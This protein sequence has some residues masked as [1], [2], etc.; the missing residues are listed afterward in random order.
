MRREPRRLVDRRAELALEVG[1][2]RLVH[3]RDL[4][5]A[6]ERDR[7]DPVL[8]PFPLPLHDRGREEDVEA[9][10]PHLHGERGEE[11]A[12]LVN[13]DQEGEAPDGDEDVHRPLVNQLTGER[14]R[15]LPR[16][17]VH[18]D[19][20]VE[21][22]CRGGV[23]RVQRFLDDLRDP[24]EGQAPVQER[25]DGDLVGGVQHARSGAPGL[26][27]RPRQREARERLLVRAR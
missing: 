4:H 5:V 7:A 27:G 2:R 1:A 8:D 23:G 17:G 26:T 19:E 13:E 18:G 20:L 14:R 15:S 21:V 10:G 12:R 9:P 6:A 16:L 11:V 3:P 22:V 25:G 24:E